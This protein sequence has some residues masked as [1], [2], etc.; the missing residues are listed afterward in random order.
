MNLSSCPICL[1]NNVILKELV[2]HHSLCKTCLMNWLTKST[3]EDV[4]CPI[5]RQTINFKGFS[6]IRDKIESKRLENMYDDLY[7][8]IMDEIIDTY[9][10]FKV[11]STAS[12]YILNYILTEEMR[13]MD[14][15]FK[16]YTQ[17]FYEE[18][19]II[20]DD[21]INN[22][23]A[24]SYKKQLARDRR[25]SWNERTRKQYKHETIMKHKNY[26]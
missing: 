14:Q 24:L 17:L 18:P 8:D 1:D 5:C 26:R 7:G 4:S 16:V 12:C 22:G 23:I 10:Q 25:A 2:C 13:E 15:T 21:I 20:W 6:K 3:E 9:H 11:D 19:D